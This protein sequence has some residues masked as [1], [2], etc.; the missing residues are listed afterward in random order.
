MHFLE[1]FKVYFLAAALLG[2]IVARGDNIFRGD[3]NL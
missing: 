2:S 1:F 3:N